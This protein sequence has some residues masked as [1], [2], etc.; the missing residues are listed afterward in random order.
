MFGF[1]HLFRVFTKTIFYET[2]LLLLPVFLF[3]TSL[4]H[5]QIDKGK[6]QIGGDLNFINNR[7]SQSNDP[8]PDY[9]NFT[10]HPTIGR[11]Y[12]NNKLPGLFLKFYIQKQL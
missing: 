3:A 8:T 9:T 6:V 11:F 12:A 10:I 7:Y 1:A 2:A 4:S 5:A